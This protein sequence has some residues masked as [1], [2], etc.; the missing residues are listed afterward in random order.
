MMIFNLHIHFL[1]HLLFLHLIHARLFYHGLTHADYL[2]KAKELKPKSYRLVYLSG[3]LLG[4]EKHTRYIVIFEKE[5]EIDPPAGDWKV[6]D[7]VSVAGL[8]SADYHNEWEKKRAAGFEAVVVN[9]YLDDKGVDRY[10]GVWEKRTLGKSGVGRTW[11]RRRMDEKELKERTAQFHKEQGARLVHLSGYEYKGK[12][13]YGA[14]WEK[15]KGDQPK[16]SVD[17]T[18]SEF[19]KEDKKLESEGYWLKH[20]SPFTV[21][22]EARYAGVWEKMGKKKDEMP[23]LQVN[24]NLNFTDFRSWRENS[25]YTGWMPLVASGNNVVGK[26][27]YSMI[28]VNKRFKRSDLEKINREVKGFMD[29]HKVPGLTMAFSDHERLV[30]AK[31]WGFADT[32]R[33]ELSDPRYR[34]RIASVSKPITAIATMYLVQT[35]KLKLT[36]K[37]FGKGARLGTTYGDPKK[38]PYAKNLTDITI[39]H[40]LEHTSGWS[41]NSSFPDPTYANA[42]IKLTKEEL[43][44]FLLDNRP[45]DHKPGTIHEYFNMNYLLLGK[46]I[47]VVTNTPY[48]TYVRNSILKDKAKITQMQIGKSKYAD[49]LPHEAAYYPG[50]DG[51]DPYKYNMQRKEA[52]GGWIARPID[53]L[54][55]VSVVD[56]WG[57][58]KDTI[59]DAAH[60][61]L[62]YTR[63]KAKLTN[64]KDA[65]YAKGWT[66]QND[67][68]YDHGGNMPGTDAI[69]MH[70]PDEEKVAYAAMINTRQKEDDDLPY[71]DSSG[72]ELEEMM[73]RIRKLMNGKWPKHDLFDIE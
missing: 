42:Q 36:D 7:W 22:G 23:P 52:N 27:T 11:Q 32:A 67:G 14:I 57:D 8:N 69:L 29:K 62:M 13:G 58:K 71:P 4:P 72:K 33:G 38:Q 30:F 43:I 59:L 18:L 5:N 10:V 2:S 63:T 55:L 66:I 34:F 17:L 68:S 21:K 15:S 31:G 60:L 65:K 35:G 49:R 1:L 39:Q 16:Y 73:V 12:A 50:H 53:L 40:L 20:I 9:G 51:T 54:Q 64:T 47:Q 45:L 41:G 46:I 24:L 3:Y 70:R 48:E 44:T 28:H 25:K 6:T 61:K 37:V 26:D 56:Q 19:L